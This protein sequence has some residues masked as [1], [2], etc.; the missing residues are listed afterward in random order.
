M[1]WK[2]VNRGFHIYVL[3]EGVFEE[4]LLQVHDF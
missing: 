1:F 2:T 3:E 4:L